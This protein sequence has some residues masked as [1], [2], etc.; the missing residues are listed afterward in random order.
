MEK[1]TLEQGEQILKGLDSGTISL[2]EGLAL[3]SGGVIITETEKKKSSGPSSAFVAMKE[4]IEELDQ[5]LSL[6]TEDEDAE[7][8]DKRKGKVS[9]EEALRILEGR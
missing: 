4:R 3:L 6:L 8:E 1:L 9:D 7:D 2:E 5:R